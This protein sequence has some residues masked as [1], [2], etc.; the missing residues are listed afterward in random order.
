M[1]ANFPSYNFFD[2]MT[3]FPA[4]AN[5]QWG[6]VF[7]FIVT[8]ACLVAGATTRQEIVSVAVL[9]PPLLGVILIPLVYL[10]GVRL[11]NRLCGII[12]ALLSCGH[13]GKFF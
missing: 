5:I 11:H 2:P 4:G 8:M 10:I 13:A 12:A 6:P 3:F 1:Q 9:I 7:P